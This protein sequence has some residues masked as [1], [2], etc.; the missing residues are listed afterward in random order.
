MAGYFENASIT[1]T[2]KKIRPSKRIWV[3]RE[4]DCATRSGQYKSNNEPPRS[5]SNC[6]SASKFKSLEN[7]YGQ[8]EHQDAHA[9][10]NHCSHSDDQSTH[11]A[12]YSSLYTSLA[13][14]PLV[15]VT[16]EVPIILGG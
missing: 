7:L 15:C 3:R 4:R 11:H 6:G 10:Q 14:P 16:L 9:G 1:P 12:I 5:R 8:D 2:A 13:H